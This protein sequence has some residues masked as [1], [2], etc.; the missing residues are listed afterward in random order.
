MASEISLYK[1]KSGTIYDVVNVPDVDLLKSL[2]IR[3]G[4]SIEVICRYPLGGPVLVRVE[5]LSAVAIGKD[6]A[7]LVSV[8]AQQTNSSDTVEDVA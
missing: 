3:E 8:K 4:A 2:G 5:E 6:I 7:T 1:A